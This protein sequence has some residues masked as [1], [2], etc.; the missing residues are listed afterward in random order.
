MKHSFAWLLFPLLV[1]VF[2]GAFMA[3]ERSGVEYQIRYPPMRFL[4][5]THI[6]EDTQSDAIHAKTL[7]LYDS[8][9]IYGEE[10]VETV[11]DTLDS[12]RVTYNTYDVSSGETY[13]IEEY[14]SVVVALF[15]LQNIETLILYLVDWVDSGGKVLFSIRPDPSDTFTAIYRKLGIISA[16]EDLVIVQGIKFTDDLLP[17][18]EGTSFNFDFLVHSSFPCSLDETAIIH[19]VSSDGFNTPLIWS[20]N[21]GDGR[22]VVIN[23][24]QF[25]TKSSRGII[26][27]SYSQLYD[28]FAYPVIN[29]SMFFIDD[30]PS[31]I[32]QGANDLIMEQYGRDIQSFLINVWWPDIEAIGKEFDLYYTGV[33]IET[34]N[35]HVTPP[36]E[37][38]PE[39]ERHQY[40]GGLLLS[41]G[42]E[43][44]LHGYNHVPLCLAEENINQVMGYPGWSSI[45]SIELSM[46]E[47]Y[48]FAKNLFPDNEFVTYVPTSNVLCEQT[49]ALLP[50]ILPDLRVISS[51]YLEE[52]EGLEYKQEFTEAADGIIELPRIIAGYDISDYM[53][54][55][56]MNELGLHYVNSHFAHPDDVISVDRGALKGWEYLRDKFNT[57]IIW[58]YDSAPGIRNMTA[59]EGAMAVQRYDRLLIDSKFDGKTYQLN[60]ENFY[61]EAWFIMQSSTPPIS[62]EGGTIMKISS[63]RYLIEALQP[64][65]TIQ[66]ME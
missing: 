44:G 52:E 28:V 23:S 4:P 5:P 51:V 25:N 50:H 26:G 14:D 10:H 64:I 66:I 43:L 63:N 33:M 24:D 30:F 8:E 59:Q 16:G 19:A 47:L 53:L 56:A 65:I 15:D 41:M 45:E 60:L 6:V 42:G 38:Q 29:A 58:L 55:A 9:F 17:G 7:V 62:I 18:T 61:D 37:K 46:F 21:H 1:L 49:R 54:W 27:A 34:Y 31:P 48:T 32:P 20:Y 2:V 11:L 12:M 35:D 36:F 39:I 3:Y 57:Y 40:F 13:N 22:F